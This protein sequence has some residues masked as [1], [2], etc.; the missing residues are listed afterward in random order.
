INRGML[1]S[2]EPGT[3]PCTPHGILHLIKTVRERISGLHAVILGRSQIV[4]RPLASLLLNSDCSVTV[5][6]SRS[7][8][9]SEICKTADILVSAV[10]KP[11]L[12]GKEFVKP[13]A[14]VIDVGINRIV[15]P[16]ET[17]TVV[18]DVDF[19]EVCEVAGA[20]TPVP[21]GVGPMTVAYLMH[22]TVELAMKQNCVN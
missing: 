8:N 9:T 10:G 4:G 18:G 22:N 15:N 21:N 1:A 7:Q 6:H 19:D 2:G 17:K 16:D 14:I 3:I 5:L 12:V 11:K 13:G 20:I